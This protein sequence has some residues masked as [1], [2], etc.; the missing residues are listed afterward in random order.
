MRASSSNQISTGVVAG[1][2]PSRWAFPARAGSFPEASTIRSSWS[3]MARPG[4]HGKPSFLRS[5]PAAGAGEVGTDLYGDDALEINPSPAHD[6]VLLTIRSRLDNLRELSQLRRRKAGLGTTPSVVDEAS[7]PDPLKRWTQSR[8]SG[9]PC[10][11]SAAEPR[12]MPSRT[13][14][15][16]QKPPALVDVLHDRRANAQFMPNNPLAISPLMAWRRSS[17][18][19]RSAP[20]Q[21]E[22]PYESASRAFGIRPRRA[23]AHRLAAN[24]SHR[25][26]DPFP[27]HGDPVPANF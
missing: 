9:G 5:F 27:A 14:R 17:A 21:S 10:R 7:G 3:R 4:A 18:P 23:D 24:K 26:G 8:A 22:I 12:S 1:A 19:T 11:R 2:D 6:A 16:R 25:P 15:Q 20:L 13:A